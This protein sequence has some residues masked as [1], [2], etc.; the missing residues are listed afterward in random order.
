MI[1]P[2]AFD[3]ADLVVKPLDFVEFAWI[4]SR[5]Y[6]DT[7]TVLDLKE[8]ENYNVIVQ[9][10]A[11]GLGNLVND[12][13]GQN[14]LNVSRSITSSN[15]TVLA[16]LILSGL[17]IAYLPRDIFEYALVSGELSVVNTRPGLP[18]IQYVVLSKKARHDDF[19]QFVTAVAMESCNFSLRP[20]AYFG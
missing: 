7:D 9:E 18:K 13:L 17:G 6:L 1:V 10:S 19:V 5:H 3:T 20:P 8:L 2:D 14:G 11:S 12:W 16:S 15:L 4:C